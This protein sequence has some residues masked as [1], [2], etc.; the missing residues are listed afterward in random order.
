MKI[1]TKNILTI[2]ELSSKEFL[3]LIDFSIKLKSKKKKT[4]G[5]LL[6]ENKTLAMIFEKPSTRT[7]VSFETGMLQLGGHAI[8]LSLNDMQHSRGESVKDTAKALSRYVDAI[9]ARVYEHSFLEDLAKYATVPVIN[10]LSNSYHPC[11]TLAD[12]MTVKEYK[13]KFKDIKIA[14]VGDGNNVCNS[15]IFVTMN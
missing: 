12:L 6:L 15:L 11:Q 14:W 1:K 2:D 8:S 4:K 3:E 9:V 10:G 7:R 5:K 13:K